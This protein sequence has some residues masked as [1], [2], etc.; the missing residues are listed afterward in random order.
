M[1]TALANS[2]LVIFF[3]TS[4]IRLMGILFVATSSAYLV[5]FIFPREADERFHEWYR[6]IRN[7]VSENV[8][9]PFN[10]SEQSNFELVFL[11]RF[12]A[13]LCVL[14]FLDILGT[15]MYNRLATWN[16]SLLFVIVF[17]LMKMYLFLNI[18][19]TVEDLELIY[20]A[21]NISRVVFVIKTVLILVYVTNLTLGMILFVTPIIPTLNLRTQIM[22]VDKAIV[23]TKNTDQAIS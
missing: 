23:E 14:F 5:G 1:I 3:L 19:P 8:E 9:R 10:S 21:T 16:F 20:R 11:S 17:G 6:K 2:D 15:T 13:P 12:V 22:A 4:A 7:I 18:G